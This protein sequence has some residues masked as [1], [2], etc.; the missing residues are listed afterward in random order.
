MLGQNELAVL[1]Y[2]YDHANRWVWGKLLIDDKVLPA[3]GAYTV[4][5]RMREA[6][7]L[8]DRTEKVADS[9]R[10]RRSFRLTAYGA[11]IY[12]AERRKSELQALPFTPYDPVLSPSTPVK[13]R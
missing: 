5:S 4:L 10:P 1:R 9:K 2:I 13:K 6:G 8:E 3:G 7:Y 11:Q 12:E